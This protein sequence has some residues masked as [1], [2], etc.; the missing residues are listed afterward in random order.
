MKAIL[1]GLSRIHSPEQAYASRY[2]ITAMAT[3][4]TAI[5][6]LDTTVV[7]VAMPNMMG[8]LGATLDEVAWVTTGYAIANV[9]VLPI[10]SWLGSRFG[11]RNYF[12]L[13]IFLFTLASILCGTASSVEELVFWR[14]VQ[15][16]AGGGLIPTSQL[17]LLQVF[18]PLEV[19][20]A[21]GI[22]GSG[23][24]VGPALGPIIG[25]WITDHFSWPW[26]FYINLPIGLLTLFMALRYMPE[27]PDAAK[28]GRIDVPGLLLLAITVG[29]G[30]ALIERGERQGWFE[31]PEIMIY[32]FAIAFALPLFI[33]YERRT[34]NPIIDLDVFRNRQFVSCLPIGVIIGAVTYMASMSLPVYLQTLRGYTAYEAGFS[35]L[36][37]AI[38]LTFCFAI[39]GKLTTLPKLDLRYLVFI[40]LIIVAASMMMHGSLTL[41]SGGYDFISMQVWRSIGVAM[42]MM[43]M[44]SLSVT[45]LPAHQL[46][47]GNSLFNLFRMLGGSL[48]IAAFTSLLEQRTHINRGELAA[49]VNALSGQA[50]ERLEQLRQMFL[51]HGDPPGVAASRAL[52]VLDGTVTQ[53]AMMSAY[54]QIYTLFACAVLVTLLAVPLMVT[55]RLTNRGAASA[56][57]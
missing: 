40:G 18:P 4:A 12:A 8:T 42:A 53:H 33:W 46:G 16:F 14:I 23:M 39:V 51:A 21:L 54:N 35:Q 47:V 22:W 9:I 29:C 27:S 32:A 26:I 20:L 30:Q 11:Q 52:Q 3:L 2:A 25:G 13:S 56:G 43:P 48:G 44:S 24:T 31:S 45:L 17:V 7:G 38:T 5:E 34:E 49:H 36:P 10:S 50:A 19:G 37:F 55:G 41:Q 6:I 15:G 57:H 28:P 1:P